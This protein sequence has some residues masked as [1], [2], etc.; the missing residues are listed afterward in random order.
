MF[1]KLESREDV[2]G[3]G[4]GLAL[5]KRIVEHYGGEITVETA[6]PRGAIFRFTW[7]RQIEVPK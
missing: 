1:Q 4:M 3:T 5:A 2:E 6:E 7:P